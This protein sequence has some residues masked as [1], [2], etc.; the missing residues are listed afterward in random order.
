MVLGSTEDTLAW[1]RSRVSSLLSHIDDP[2]LLAILGQKTDEPDLQDG[3]CEP[4]REFRP[5]CAFRTGE[6]F[7]LL[8]DSW[9][10]VADL[11]RE[12]ILRGRLLVASDC[13]P[14]L[15]S[16]M[17]VSVVL[18]GDAGSLRLRAEVVHVSRTGFG[19]KLV[20]LTGELT[21]LFDSLIEHAGEGRPGHAWIDAVR[22]GLRTRRRGA[23]A[24]V[25]GLSARATPEAIQDA[26]TH[27]RSTWEFFLG[28]GELTAKL[29]PVLQEYGSLLGR[30]C[31]RLVVPTESSRQESGPAG[32]PR[33]RPVI[34]T[35]PKRPKSQPVA[36]A[37]MRAPSIPLIPKAR[38]AEPSR[39]VVRNA[40]RFMAR[41][42]PRPRARLEEEQSTRVSAPRG[43]GRVYAHIANRE[44]DEAEGLLCDTLR[45]D[46]QNDRAQQLLH[47][48]RARRA[49]KARDF[50]SAKRIYEA[51]LRRD[52]QNEAAQK[53]LIMISALA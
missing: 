37:P 7:E 32:V 10:R 34:P 8:P 3:G 22:R 45:R 13:E 31:A 14:R 15:R 47:L 12:D 6:A 17:D 19:L 48:V 44:Y 11:Y 28:D 30:V 49:V 35:I 26:Y 50:R 21:F 27:A 25:L 52:P 46:P 51:L 4:L 1:A 16:A 23:D 43:L 38:T 40:R 39:A 18:P 24:R 20:P 53:E 41:L 2:Q 29:R 33:P 36:A 42:A 9:R 5:G